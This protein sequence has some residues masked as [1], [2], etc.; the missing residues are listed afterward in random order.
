MLETIA[1]IPAR[2]QRFIDDIEQ[3]V[4]HP[5]IQRFIQFTDNAA[6]QQRQIEK[7]TLTLR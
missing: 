3:I 2:I 4:R 5:G 6:A 1:A 7:N